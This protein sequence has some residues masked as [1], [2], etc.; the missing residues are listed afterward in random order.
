MARPLRRNT[1]QAVLAGVA[2]GFADYLDLDPVLVRLGFIVLTLFGGSGIL[3]YI[4][5]WIIMPAEG[6]GTPADRMASDAARAGEKVVDDLRGA[7]HGPERARTIG[8]LVLIVLGLLFLLDRI[9]GFW[10]PFWFRWHDLWPAILIIIG[11]ALVLKA[12]RDGR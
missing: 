5:S 2:A 8:G 11:L 4:V 3:L 10:H 12:G 6:A 9:P 1:R 7:A